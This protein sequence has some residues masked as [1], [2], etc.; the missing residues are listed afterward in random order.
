MWY[1]MEDERSDESY[2]FLQS[3]IGDELRIQINAGDEV[4]SALGWQLLPVQ[5]LT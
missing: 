2:G 5:K 4:E 3:F 1:K